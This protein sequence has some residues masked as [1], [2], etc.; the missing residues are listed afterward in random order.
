[1]QK[2]GCLNCGATLIPG[3]NFCPNC[4]QKTG[5]PR[6]TTRS[7]LRDFLQTILHAEKGIFNLLRGLARHPGRVVTEYVEG[8][9]KKYFNPFSFLALCIAFMVLMNGWLKPYQDVPV[10]NQQVIVR[11]PDEK[12][13]ELY[14]LTV[15][16]SAEA[17]GF[18]NRN[19]NFG[20]LITAPFYAVFLWLFFKRRGRNMAEIAVAYILLTAF[21]DVLFTVL[22][23][24][25]LALYRG[26]LTHDYI[27]WAGL[28]LETFY[29]AWGLKT[30][31]G[32]STKGGYFKVLLALWLTGLIG[33][34]L[35]MVSYFIY[36]YH[37]GASVVLRYL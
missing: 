28:I 6:I 21:I 8:K 33:L 31:F 4:G 17:Q 12:T 2:T 18:F 36:V 25:W 11:L 16:R 19:M 13:K 22:A 20:T 14:L 37:G 35:L 29:Y 10:P 26:S 5:I 30:F 32:Y 3:Q 24:P 34:V 27:F 9:R 23:S 1:M 15:K 7:L